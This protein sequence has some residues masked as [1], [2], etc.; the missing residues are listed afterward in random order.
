M[1]TIIKNGIQY[2][3]NPNVAGASELVVTTPEVEV[4]D[5]AP[6]FDS[7]Y[8]TFNGDELLNIAG[9]VSDKV[10]DTATNAA[11]AITKPLFKMAN[12][13]LRNIFT[14]PPSYSDSK[15]TI[16]NDLLDNG[17]SRLGM[18]GLV[19]D[20][21]N[22]H[23][24]HTKNLDKQCAK[25]ANQLSQVMAN[26]PTAGDAWTT[27]GI[28]GDS[29]IVSGYKLPKIGHYSRFITD[30]YNRT[31]AEYVKHNIEDKDLQTGDIVDLYYYKSP[32]QKMAYVNGDNRMNTH[33]GRILKTDPYDK[34][35]TFVV[36]NV[37]G[38]VISQP[39]GDLLGGLGKVGITAIRRPF[40]KNDKR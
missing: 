28:Y 29:T 30:L 35:K 3:V 22:E 20:E 4:V 19:Q 17:R 31:A 1:P 18:Y 10:V 26:R 36:H 38:N 6:L 39:I 11:Y 34:S 14:K 27:K 32:K 2:N 12:P 8:S 33:T 16:Y 40:T 24:W 13:I 37:N 5:K 15:G 25:V 9:D 7:R 21:N 23:V